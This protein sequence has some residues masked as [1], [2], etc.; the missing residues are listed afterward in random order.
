MK[1]NAWKYLLILSALF[2]LANGVKFNS[3]FPMQPNI[4]NGGRA[5]AIAVD[6]NNENNIVVAS[7]SGGLFRSLTHGAKWTQ[8]S[9]GGTFWF[10]DV[11]YLPSNDNIVLATAFADSRV[12]SGG[13][14]WR[15]TDG[16][17]SW[18]RV[19][20]NAPT[21]DCNNNFAAYALAAETGQDRVWAG[22][23]CGLAYSDDEGASWTFLP[24]DSVYKQEPVFAVLTPSTDRL[25]ISTYE[26]IKV[27]SDEGSTWS[28]STTGLPPFAGDVG[29]PHNEIAASPNNPDTLYWALN[30]FQNGP[31]V[32]LFRSL[33]NGSTWSSLY[34]SPGMNRPPF[35]R[36]AQSLTGE[37]QAY[38]IYFS[39]GACTLQRGTAFGSDSIF[40]VWTKLAVDHCDAADIGFSND[41]KTPIL[42]ASD[43]GLHSTSN[44]GLN[45]TFVGGGKA[46]YNALQV[47]EVTGQ[48]HNDGLSADLYMGTQDNS[49]WA[50]PDE[51]STWPASF[52]SEGFYLDVPRDFFP[53]NQT[54]VTGVYCLPCQ[55]FISGPVF[56]GLAGF[57]DA[58]NSVDAPHLLQPGDYIQQTEE[59]NSED[60]FFSLTTTTGAS[61]TPRF[62]FP[63][64]VWGA[65]LVA[66]L[67]DE[68]VVYAAVHEPGATS[69]GAPVV[70]LKRVSDI[71]GTSTPLVS[72]ISGFGSLGIHGFM[73]ASYGSFGVD[74][75]DPN[76]LMVSDIVDNQVKVSTDA[77]ATWTPDTTLT[78][79]VT[80]S[81]QYKFSW[82]PDFTQTTAFAFDPDCAGHILVGTQQ[83]G[84]FETFDRGGSWLKLINS[85]LISNVSSIF[86]P[87]NG[88]LVIS[89]YGR[90]LWTYSYTCPPRPIPPSQLLQF[91]EPLIY[92]KGARIPIS[93]IHDPEVCPACGYFLVLGGKVLDYKTNPDTGQLTQ[94]MITRGEIKGYNWQGEPLPLP[95]QVV[96]GQVQ[97]AIGG[98]NL[99]QQL[100]GVTDQV[101]GLFV[102]GDTL[103]GLIVYSSDLTVDQ[104]PKMMPLAP[105]INLS[106]RVARAIDATEP[107]V[108]T[109]IGFDPHSP[110]EVLLDGQALRLDHPVDFDAQ[111]NFTFSFQ[112]T[113]G[114]GTHVIWVRQSTPRGVIQDASAFV[115]SVADE[116]RQ[117]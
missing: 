98:N 78:N 16:G 102:E 59:Q 40:G 41:H 117:R 61:W 49:L 42:L 44:N 91:A 67:T 46:G 90:G 82:W 58:P 7:D 6:P 85:D 80:D 115:V 39:D 103:R 64:P 50:S 79:L 31:H 86:F 35:V 63:E 38:D 23:L 97:G 29:G 81:G 2:L 74:P 114:L 101:K 95:F 3:V 45:W 106:V 15:S 108:V 105:H 36:T 22:T 68:E 76:F 110:L 30:Y 73:T 34:D 51:G 56:S 69:D 17:A 107:L 4:A 99:F 66:G 12:V 1:R 93:Q 113:V 92:W 65:P 24:D 18:A 54:N 57:P 111:G 94:V 14:I 33:D 27:S 32:A 43:G 72:N 84:V 48:L 70:E 60:T 116:E 87:G 71:L 21:A 55:H 10:T 47:Y 104:L 52:D 89:S 9:A 25:V 96:Q 62:S 53:A 20:V 19:S 5:V 11:T 100:H 8:V 77:G 26:G 37:S 83:A 75:K 112:P 13:G 28:I 88:K 109:G